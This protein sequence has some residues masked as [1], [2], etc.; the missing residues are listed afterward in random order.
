MK[1]NILKSRFYSTFSLERPAINSSA[2][3]CS[4]LHN[5]QNNKFNPAIAI[6]EELENS[7]TTRTNF[8]EKVAQAVNIK[9]DKNKYTDLISLDV[10]PRDIIKSHVL[11]RA[12]CT[13]KPGKG[14]EVEPQIMDFY[15]EDFEEESA[16]FEFNGLDEKDELPVVSYDYAFDL[17]SH[18]RCWEHTWR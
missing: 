1:F 10:V 11:Q 16:K 8:A 2:R 4:K 17:Y 18:M 7:E 9:R 12:P 13:A 14:P 15:S 5:L 6:A 3:I